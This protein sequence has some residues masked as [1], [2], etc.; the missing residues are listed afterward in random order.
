MSTEKTNFYNSARVKRGFYHFLVGKGITSIA[1]FLVAILIV[2]ELS[3]NDYANYTAISGLLIT[4]MLISNF[5]IER[6][7]PKYIAKA[8]QTASELEL[9]KLTVKLIQYRLLGLFITTSGMI[10]FSNVI[11]RRFGIEF[12]AEILTGF[13]LY[14]FGFGMSMHM[15]RTLQALLMQKEATFTMSIEWFCKLSVILLLVYVYEAMTLSNVL[16]VQ[17]GTILLSLCFATRRLLNAV[18]TAETALLQDAVVDN[19]DLFRFSLNNY[20]QT[21]AGFHCN[22]STNKLIGSALLAPSAIASLGFAYSITSVFHRYLPS[23]LFIGLIEP[24]IMGR[25]SKSSNF[26][27]TRLYTGLLLKINLFIVMPAVLWFIA[28]GKHII[29]IITKGKYGN[30][31]WLI[32]ALL[33]ALILESQRAILQLIANA[34]DRSDLLLKTNLYTL[35]LLPV[36]VLL[37]NNFGL[38]GLIIGILLTLLLRN[39]I[40]ELMLAKLSYRLPYDFFAIIK[41]VAT[42]FLSVFLINKLNFV[43]F[44]SPAMSSILKLALVYL[45]YLIC[46]AILK[47]FSS[48]ERSFL[49]RFMGRRGFIW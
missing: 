23:Q 9:K 35:V 27:E 3:I 30:T 25:F 40:L 29:D 46:L 21:L 17:A 19:R 7:V 41:I 14:A 49:N 43:E 36:S 8:K 31:A 26:G 15:T 32:S 24:V 16:Y 33:I 5:G 42:S 20:L 11:F 34:V 2:R 6:A 48:Q 18:E 44:L 4:F 37:T 45:L 39:G 10:I 13:C 12:N 22:A 38:H 1:S 47:P 28:D